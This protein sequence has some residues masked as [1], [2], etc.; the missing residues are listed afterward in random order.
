M[1]KQITFYLLFFLF[2]FYLAAP[3][4]AQSETEE[5][6]SD[7]PS[8]TQGPTVIPQGTVQIEAGMQYQKDQTDIF[9][10]KEYLYPE[11]L[12]RIS[13]L[14]WAELRLTSEFK[15]ENQEMRSGGLGGLLNSERGFNNVQVGTKI[16]FYQGQ[17]AIPEIGFLGN[18]TLPVGNESFR[19]A[20]VAPEGSLLFNNKI[21]EKLG[22]QYNVGYGKQQNQD[23]YQGQLFYGAEFDVKIS[24]K[25]QTYGEFYSQ[26]AKASPAENLVDIGLQVLL[27]P[28]LQFDVVGGTGVSEEAPKYFVGTGLTWRLPH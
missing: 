2:S 5:L 6:N 17:G 10:T 27:L 28:N 19:P 16:N 21:T 15:K 18:I 7:R 12:I 22:L 8:R 20:H 3:V 14:E 1:K 25:V 26:K 23:E 9:L 11:A 4:W 24:D 13:L